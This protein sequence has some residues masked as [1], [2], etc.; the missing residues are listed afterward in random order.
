MSFGLVFDLQGHKSA[1]L[2]RQTRVTQSDPAGCVHRAPRSS[3]SALPHHEYKFVSSNP[4]SARS[5]R[6][7]TYNTNAPSTSP[8]RS[9]ARR[10]PSRQGSSRNC[11]A[12]SPSLMEQLIF[13]AFNSDCN[14]CTKATV[15]LYNKLFPALNGTALV[16]NLCGA[17]FSATINTIHVGISHSAV[18]VACGNGVVL[19]AATCGDLRLRPAT[20]VYTETCG[21]LDLRPATVRLHA[22][23]TVHLPVGGEHIFAP[24][25]QITINDDQSLRNLEIYLKSWEI[26]HF[27]LILFEFPQPILDPQIDSGRHRVSSTLRLRG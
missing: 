16:E 5:Q 19:H 26:P 27:N 1:L 21:E 8:V 23:D 24:I 3:A 12:P 15:G 13:G 25:L 18:D 4:P 6:R 11:K 9:S 17:N 10:S 2:F 14:V 22:V 7:N 20:Y